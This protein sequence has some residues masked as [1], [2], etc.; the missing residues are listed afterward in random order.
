VAFDE[1]YRTVYDELRALAH[2]VRAGRG[3]E[4]LNTTALVHEAY[5]KLVPS[6]RALVRDRVHFFGIAA[7][8]M[9][10][11][12]VDAARRR[13]AE[14]RGGGAPAVEF[15]EAL[16]APDRAGRAAGDI[17]DRILALNEALEQLEAWHPRQ[18]DVVQCRVFAGLT[19]ADTAQALGVSEPTIKRDWQTA[20][21]WLVH[22]LGEG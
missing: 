8:A 9:R 22:R 5:V 7:R 19:V 2:A 6:P 17:A 11:V 3:S 20:R 18:A 15:D 4:T 16:Y 21:A 10:Q 1:V 12:L 13:Q 14:K